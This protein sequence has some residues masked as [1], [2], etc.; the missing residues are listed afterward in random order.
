MKGWKI[1]L[2]IFGGVMLGVTITF[3][4][5]MFQLMESILN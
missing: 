4:W 2:L 3:C 1:A 5:F